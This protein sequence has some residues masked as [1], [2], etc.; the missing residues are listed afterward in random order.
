M[1]SKC[2]ASIRRTT[3]F[4]LPLGLL[5]FA[6]LAR[7][8][9][10]DLLP[11]AGGDPLP[12]SRLVTAEDILRLRDIGTPETALWSEPSPLALSPDGHSVALL[13]NRADPDSNSYCR[14][15]VVVSLEGA[16]GARALDR[17]GDLITVMGTFGGLLTTSGMPATVTPAWSPDGRWIAYLRRDHGVTQLWR[18]RADG[19]AEDQGPARPVTR[20]PVDVERFAWSEDGRSLI[21]SVTPALIAAEKAID[22][23]G[24]SGWLSDA[25]VMPNY[26]ARPMVSTAV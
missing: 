23:E 17:G 13:I 14:A 18:V 22:Q 12:V 26:R 11:P 20:S 21:Y 15:L 5:L 16:H 9:C 4:G 8:S 2:V 25:R 7:A 6:P 24:R 1:V 10:E 19:K 3:L